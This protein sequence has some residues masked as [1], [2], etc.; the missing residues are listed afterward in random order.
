[1]RASRVGSARLF[2]L[3]ANSEAP[4]Y[5]RTLM[6]WAGFDQYTVEYE[7]VEYLIKLSVAL[8]FG[9]FFVDSTVKIQRN[10]GTY[11]YLAATALPCFML[12]VLKKKKKKCPQTGLRGLNRNN[13]WLGV[14]SRILGSLAEFSK[15][16]LD[17]V[18]GLDTTRGRC[19]LIAER[20]VCIIAHWLRH[21]RRK[22]RMNFSYFWR[23]HL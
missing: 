23:L 8:G 16:Q 5:I 21:W 13:T 20:L 2:C 14:L 11:I 10:R 6:V 15:I 22:W 18:I 9:C 1:M 12:H 4:W 7:K 3:L 17:L 19:E